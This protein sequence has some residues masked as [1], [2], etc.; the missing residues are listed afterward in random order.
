MVHYGFHKSP[1]PD[2]TLPQINSVHVLYSSSVKIHFSIILL[3]M[4]MSSYL[5]LSS[6]PTKICR[7]SLHPH[8]YNIPRPFHLSWFY[9]PYNILE[10][11]EITNFITQLSTVSCNFQPL[12]PR[13]H[14]QHHDIQHPQLLIFPQC[15]RA[16]FTL[17]QNN[18]QNYSFV[19]FCI[20]SES[21][22]QTRIVTNT[23]RI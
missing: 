12:S 22:L 11:A 18:R 5:Q 13:N 19:P 6:S 14:P 1:P 7:L 21:K 17:M 8:L 20:L 16:N 15:E 4:T 10:G 9:N 3:F 2:P 23:P